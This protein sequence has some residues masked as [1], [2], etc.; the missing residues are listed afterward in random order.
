MGDD[1]DK[2]RVDAHAAANALAAWDL[3]AGDLHSG[4]KAK[5]QQVLAKYDNLDFFGDDHPGHVAREGFG[6]EQFEKTFSHGEDD[7]NSGAGYVKSTVDLGTN[8]RLAI[9]MS[10]GSDDQQG[11]EIEKAK[12]LLNDPPT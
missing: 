12:K 6:K 3:T 7:E 5:V 1:A 4:Y 10:L 11:A 9:N 2:V 8:T